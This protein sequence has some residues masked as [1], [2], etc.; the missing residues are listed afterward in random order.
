MELLTPHTGTIIWMT[1]AF[2][3]VF[4]VLKKFAWKPILNALKTRDESIGEALKSADRARED[5]ARLQA[6][7]EN[8]LAEARLERDK[9]IKEARDLKEEIIGEAKNKAVEEADKLIASARE[10]IKNEKTAAIREIKEQIAEFSVLIAEK[11]LQE[12]LEQDTQQKDLINKYLHEIK[13]N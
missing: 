9:I 4:L 7:N 8:I 1:I 2:L 3:V 10:S 12:K 11:L 6:D 5:M 13:I